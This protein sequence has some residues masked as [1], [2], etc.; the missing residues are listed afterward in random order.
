MQNVQWVE[1]T[2][3]RFTVRTRWG[4]GKQGDE[5]EGCG[6]SLLV[7]KYSETDYGDGYTILRLY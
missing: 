7:M 4:T 1:K 3:S 2:E 6:A 5:K